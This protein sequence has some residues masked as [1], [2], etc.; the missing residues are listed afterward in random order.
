MRFLNCSAS[1]FVI[2][3]HTLPRVVNPIRL[4]VLLASPVQ[5]ILEILLG[6]CALSLLALEARIPI[7]GQRILEIT[8]RSAIDLD[9]PKGRVA[10]L[11]IMTV[12]CGMIQYFMYVS[13]HGQSNAENSSLVDVAA[14]RSVDTEGIANSTSDEI[15]STSNATALANADASSSIS[16]HHT[17]WQ[18]NT[19]LYTVIQSSI[20][21]PSMWVLVSLIV[22]TMHIMQIYPDYVHARAYPEPSNG[23]AA[24]VVNASG[25]GGYQNLGAP[26]WA[27]PTV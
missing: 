9:S 1:L 5:L 4:V 16:N 8:R 15:A 12:T 27:Q 26:S 14:D 24:N 19:F 22:Y 6:C 20:I 25:V 18:A 21:S 7:I 10:V 2:V 11:T 17:T 23:S 3:V 13:K